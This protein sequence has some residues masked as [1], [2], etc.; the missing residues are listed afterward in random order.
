MAAED[1]TRDHRWQPLLVV[2]GAALLWLV[3]ALLRD[4]VTYHL[5]PVIVAAAPP[6]LGLGGASIRGRVIARVIGQE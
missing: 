3:L 6:V 2:A 1:A 4:G 5:A